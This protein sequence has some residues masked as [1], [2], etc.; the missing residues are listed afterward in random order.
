MADTSTPAPIIIKRI[1]KGG[2]AHH[3]GAWKVAYADFVTAMMAFFLLLW[4]LSVT[5]QDQR[6]AV[7]DYFTPTIGIKDSKGIGIDGGKAP[8]PKGTSNNNLTAVGIV[9]GQVQ[10]GPVAKEP[11]DATKDDPQAEAAAENKD[12]KKNDSD[13]QD[14]QDSEQ[15]KLTEQ[16]IK[17]AMENDPELQKF[18]NNVQ[19]ENTDEGMKIDLIDDPKKPMFSAGAAT[20]TEDGRKAVDSMANIV[21]KTPNQLSIIGHTDVAGPSSNPRYGNWELS[22]DRANAVRRTLV[23]TQIESGRVVKVV[24]MADR[25]LL[26]KEEPNNPRNRRVTIMLLRGSYFRDPNKVQPTGRAI[27][28]VPE[29]KVKQ[30]EPPPEASA[31]VP[32][33]PAKPSIFDQKPAE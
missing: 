32:A 19:V 24:G 14:S 21:G 12:D 25:Q 1:K 16:E 31:P 8:G 23:T 17:Q 11:N 6:K 20:L 10:Q 13:N 5:T 18:K 26:V 22:T 29:A 7:A 33:E 15:F 30:E 2:H 27:L 9:V 4:L 28:S 3:G